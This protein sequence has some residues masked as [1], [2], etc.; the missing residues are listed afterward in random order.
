MSLR[1][2]VRRM[3]EAIPALPPEEETRRHLRWLDLNEEPDYLPLIVKGFDR[4]N[5]AEWQNLWPGHI[6]YTLAEQFDDPDKMLWELL[7]QM[8][9]L[10]RFPSDG[11]LTV[12]PMYGNAFLLDGLGL[13]TRIVDD[14]LEPAAPLSRE[15]LQDIAL[16][17]DWQTRGAIGKARTF[18]ACARELLRPHI[19]VGLCFMMSPFDLAYLIRGSDIMLDMYEAPKV[20]HHLMAVCTQLFIKATQLLKQDAGE[21]DGLT[22]YFANT[23]R[24]GVLLCEDCC[25][26]LSPA[27]HRE[28]SLPYTRQALDAF[29]GGWIHFCG[30]GQHLLDAYLALPNLHGIQYGQLDLNGPVD[31]TVA[32]IAGVGKALN[33]MIPRA[34]GETWPEFFSRILKPLPAQRSLYAAANVFCD[35]PE[36]GQGLLDAWHAAQ[37]ARWSN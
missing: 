31:Q 29:D 11:T 7:V 27:L 8:V 37:D 34:E 14:C 28:F 18:I 22:R 25:V 1:D 33:C 19:H 12:M 10:R 32:C 36:V 3:I 2:D 30:D 5:L 4:N 13:P 23:W 35:Q 16:L 6:R 20:V 24:G 9:P 26:M 21:P 15:Q 17:P